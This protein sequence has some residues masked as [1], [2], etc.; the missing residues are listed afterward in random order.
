MAHTTVAEVKANRKILIENY[1]ECLHCPGVH[2]ELVALIP[3]AFLDV[4][5]TFATLTA[6]LPRTADHTTLVTEYLYAPETRADDGFDPS[7]VIAFNELVIAQDNG[8]CERVQREV[9]SRSF[10]AGV[11]PDK[12]PARVR[13]VL[14][15]AHG[16]S[17]GVAID[18]SAAAAA[19]ELS[20]TRLAPQGGRVVR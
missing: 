4:S 10:V 7:D 2:P 8:I 5:G 9:A 20:L 15:A 18:R 11:Y 17:R 3:N 14:P 19:I 6:L 13:P 1:A 16:G 12:R